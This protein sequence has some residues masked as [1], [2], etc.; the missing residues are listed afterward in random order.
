MSITSVTFILLLLF[1]GSITTIGGFPDE[2][3]CHS[4]Y[5]EI[6]PEYLVKELVEPGYICL[7]V[8]KEKGDK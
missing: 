4:V 8:V 7:K 2:K 1:P 3:S 5:L 6:L